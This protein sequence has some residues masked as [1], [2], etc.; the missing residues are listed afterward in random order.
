MEHPPRESRLVG[1]AFTRARSQGL[2]ESTDRHQRSRRPMNH[3]RPVLIW[4]SLCRCPHNAPCTPPTPKPRPRLPAAPARAAPRRARARPSARLGGD[5]GH[6]S[7]AGLWPTSQR[8]HTCLNRACSRSSA[9]PSPRA[10]HDQHVR[11][12]R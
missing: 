3:T 7:R 9:T 2:I 12:W 10:H 6:P 5:P 11:R 1:N 8:S 4:R